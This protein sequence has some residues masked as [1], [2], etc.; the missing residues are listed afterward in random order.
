MDNLEKN[1]RRV[2]SKDDFIRY[3]LDYNS[4]DCYILSIDSKSGTHIMK[5]IK[6]L[7]YNDAI[8]MIMASSSI[9]PII[10][11]IE[12]D[13]LILSDGGHRGHS[14]GAYLLKNNVDKVCNKI[15]KCFTIF[16]RPSPKEYEKQPLGDSGNFFGRLLNFTIGVSV[17][18]TSLND[19]YVEKSECEN[20]KIEYTPVYISKFTNDTYRITDEQ[21]KEGEKIGTEAVDKLFDVK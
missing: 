19:E 16:S 17:K 4:P 14:A 8:K 2:V 9:A 11:P 5:N 12:Y 10:K 3:S 13:G 1:I 15:N 20:N 7:P 18:E 6:H 21:I